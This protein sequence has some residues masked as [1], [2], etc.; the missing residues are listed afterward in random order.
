M[1]MKIA[2][3]IKFKYYL[4]KIVYYENGIPI[5]VNVEEEYIL[6]L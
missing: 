3:K 4:P 5:M 2:K 1:I 6:L